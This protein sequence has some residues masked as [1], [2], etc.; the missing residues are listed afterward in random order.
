[1]A[2]QGAEGRAGEDAR[3]RGAVETAFLLGER[4]AWVALLG[5]FEWGVRNVAW[6]EEGMDG[7]MDGWW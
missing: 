6:M 7:W 1:M 5:G 4:V 2:W 3:V